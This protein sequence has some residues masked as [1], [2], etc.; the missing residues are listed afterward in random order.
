LEEECQYIL[1]PQYGITSS[2]ISEATNSMFANA[3]WGTWLS[4]IEEIIDKMT[5]RISEAKIRAINKTGIVPSMKDNIQYMWNKCNG[6]T[7]TKLDEGAEIYKVSHNDTVGK[8]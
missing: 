8:H 3:R 6:F 4:T 1:L 2:N 5:T 7:V